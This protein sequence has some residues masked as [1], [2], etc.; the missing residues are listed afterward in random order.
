MFGCDGLVCINPD[1]LERNQAKYRAVLIPNGA[2]V[3]T[4]SPG[5]SR[6]ALFNLP[7]D[8]PIILMVSAF[9]SSKNVREGIEAVAALPT[10]VLVVAG[11]GP[12]RAQMHEM[13][14]KLLPGRFVNLT[15]TADRMPDLYRSADVFMHLS[16]DESFGN[17]YVEAMATGL[18]VVAYHSERT[19]WIVGDPGFYANRNDPTS[20]PIELKAALSAT[21]D[22]G[23]RM[24]ARARNF[25]WKTIAQ[26][27]E[28]FFQQLI[29]Q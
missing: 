29:A 17:V 25:S 27:Y 13:A 21:A 3:T 20:L 10:A 28:L 22:V 8:C 12:E 7:Q 14:A 11:D 23:E 1:Y 18:P 24:V 6:R 4:F 5:K 9:I 2:D 19:K 26:Q 16:V 15:V